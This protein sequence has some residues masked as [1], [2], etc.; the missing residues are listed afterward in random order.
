M[1]RNLQRA[2]FAVAAV[3]VAGVLGAAPAAAKITEMKFH[4][5]Q[6]ELDDVPY[7]EMAHDGQNYNWVSQ[8]KNFNIRTKVL[9]KS[10]GNR[11]WQAAIE[12]EGTNQYLWW[13]PKHKT[14]KYENLEHTTIGKTLLSSF[15]NQAAAL[16]DVFGG[17]QKT[18]RDMNIPLRMWV[19]HTGGPSVKGTLPVRVVCQRKKEPQRK[20][21]ALE[22]TS[23]K[24][25]TLPAKPV[26]G[27]PVYLVT[28]IHTNKP[29]KVEFTLHR[30]DGEQQ[31]ASLTTEKAG[32][33]Y[34]KR[35]TKQYVYNSSIK[36]EY[37][38]V[39]K[40]HPFST[41]W[42]PLAVNCGVGAD[43]KKMPLRLLK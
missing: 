3:A 15:K 21:V 8:D 31:A 29:G 10:S 41:N 2:V 34:A 19:E 25:Y 40:G 35:W 22:V 5:V 11:F 42:V 12:V 27:K 26:C 6:T 43:I 4:V 33:G 16:C 32:N 14:F 17:K 1:E 24:L 36:R 13:M 28:E 23:L 37:L 18:V 39:L 20:P 7:M 38:V 30:R 9:I